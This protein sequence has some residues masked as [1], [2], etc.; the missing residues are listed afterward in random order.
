MIT[1]KKIEM[2]VVFKRWLDI[3]FVI[4]CRII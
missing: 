2:T 3:I 1:V 4:L